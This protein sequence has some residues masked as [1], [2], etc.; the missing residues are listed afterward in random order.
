MYTTFTINK[1]IYGRIQYSSNQEFI[2]YFKNSIIDILKQD[3]SITKLKIDN[4]KVTKKTWKEF[5]TFYTLGYLYDKDEA[6]DIVFNPTSPH[7]IFVTNQVEVIRDLLQRDAERKLY[8]VINEVAL[9]S[10]NIDFNNPI[11]K[12]IVTDIFLIHNKLK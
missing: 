10:Q 5:D 12:E 11:A 3:I 1:D 6:F 8:S 7:A 2:L 9:N 4:N